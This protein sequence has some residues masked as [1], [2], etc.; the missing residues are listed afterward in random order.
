MT[1]ARIAAW[2]TPLLAA[3]ALGIW[4]I[5]SSDP[6]DAAPASG[7]PAQLNNAD[8]RRAID[9]GVMVIDIRR[10]EEWRETGVIEGSYLMTAFDQQ[11]RLTRDF[12][13]LFTETVDP[14]QPIVL[15]CRTGN[16]TGTLS[17]ILT[18]QAGYPNIH[19]V[20]DG[21]AAWIANEGSVQPCAERKP[22]LQ[23]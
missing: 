14:E 23:C 3:G 18:D 12:P 9:Q 15:I 2:L 4:L 21:I 10:P 6:D 13:T 7:L 19:H 11:G 20:T 17:R 8:L 16:R 1:R 5:G 22:N